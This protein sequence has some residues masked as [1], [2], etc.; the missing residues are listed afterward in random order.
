MKE[1]PDFLKNQKDEGMTEKE[2]QSLEDLIKGYDEAQAEVKRIEKL[3]KLA[4]DNFNHI[5]LKLVPDLLLTHGMSKISL[6]DGR[7]VKVKEDISATVTDDIAFRQWLRDRKEESIIKVKYQFTDLQTEQMS[8]LTDFLFKED[9]DF[10]I[11]ES[12]HAQTKA[13]YFRELLKVMDREDLPE[14]VSIYDIRKAT[15]K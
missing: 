1:T 9:L 8:G 3:L 11:D 4:K 7:E 12:I 6:T 5:A 10:E 14:W 15:I 13:K 2:M